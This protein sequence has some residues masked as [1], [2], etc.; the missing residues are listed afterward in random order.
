[1][2]VRVCVCMFCLMGVILGQAVGAKKRQVDKELK[3]AAPANAE[4]SRGRQ[5]EYRI[6][7]TNK[8]STM[9]KEMNQAAEAGFRYEEHDGRRDRFRRFR[10][11]PGYVKSFWS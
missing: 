6:L 7:A 8:T 10:S 2:Y 4:P 9:Q 1:M 11:G 5:Y 3:A